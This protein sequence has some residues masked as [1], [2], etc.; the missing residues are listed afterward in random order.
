MPKIAKVAIPLALNKEFDYSFSLKLKIKKGMRVLVDFKGKKMLGVVVDTSN[1]SRIKNLKPILDSLDTSPSLTEEQIC[2]AHSLSESYPYSLS[3]FVFMFLPPY[4]K[5]TRKIDFDEP[6]EAAIHLQNKPKKVFLKANTFLKR[7]EFLKSSI[8]EKLK[9]GSVLICFPQM[10]YLMNAKKILEKD[11][12]GKINIM[13]S[14][15][16]EKEL[17]SVWAKTRT[18]SLILGT[19]VSIFYYPRDLTQLIVEEENNPYYFQEE[20]P[21]HNLLDVAMTLSNIKGVDLLLSGDNLSLS[22]YQLVKEK[23]IFL[24]DRGGD[25]KKIDIINMSNFS[26]KRLIGPVLIELI[27]RSVRSKKK[28]VILWN[29][30]GFFR[31]ISCTNCGYVVKCGN[32]SGLLQKIPNENEGV[33]PYCKKKESFPK[34]CG[35]CKNGYLKEKG[36]GIDRIGYSLKKIFPDVKIDD[37]ENMNSNTQIVLS[38]SKIL[39]YLYEQGN[40]DVGLVMDTDLLLAR[41]EYDSTFNLYIYLK[42]L[43][44]Y[45]KDSLY[46]FTNNKNYYLFESL[47]KEWAN[48]YDL[49]LNLRFE[50]NLPPF[51][52]IAKIILRSK[53]EITLLKKVKFLYNK[54][55][56]KGME[57]YGPFQ[58]HPYKLRDKF[59]YSL[60][61]KG[62]R[63]LVSRKMIKEEIKGIRSSS[64]QLAVV[65]K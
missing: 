10:S 32:C 45:F 61:I 44:F 23:I 25:A 33:C 30:K 39:S 17:Y 13:H 26:V 4:L 21:F 5:K 54:L 60:I 29:K 9:E 57:V 42:K 62:K 37:F 1:Y 11:F 8:E 55:Q 20:K 65:F 27:Q 19:R 2:F 3:E 16:G 58:E 12:S 15:Q 47:N 6:F 41:P 59:R 49:E 24:E 18:K 31:T 14:Q 64:F 34:T 63:D 22:S 28:I 36:F 48:F 40:F 56:K 43:S 50:S 53:N 7:Y 38:T 51:G 46:V 35:N 52:L